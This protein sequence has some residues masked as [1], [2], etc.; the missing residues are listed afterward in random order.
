[1]IPNVRI[2]QFD[3]SALYVIEYGDESILI[4]RRFE[5]YTLCEFDSTNME[6]MC[7]L[8]YTAHKIIEFLK[9]KPDMTPVELKS[10]LS[11]FAEV[12]ILA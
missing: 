1:M 12:E 4:K 8:V 2:E 6:N 3:T 9:N 5:C 7:M 11:Q 10:A